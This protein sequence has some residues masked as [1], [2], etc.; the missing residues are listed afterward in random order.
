MDKKKIIRGYFLKYPFFQNV[1]FCE[2][3]L[4]VPQSSLKCFLLPESDKKHFNFKA[5][6]VNRIYLLLTEFIKIIEKNNN[7]M[8]ENYL[9]LIQIYKKTIAEIGTRDDDKSIKDRHRAEKMIEI[10]EKLIE[11][12][13]TNSSV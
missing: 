2:K 7:A 8:L 13:K 11:K 4:H 1:Y 10:T 9:K 6:K 12:L 5:E 3:V